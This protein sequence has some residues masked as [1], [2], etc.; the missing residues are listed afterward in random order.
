MAASGSTY[1]SKLDDAM[2]K[3]TDSWFN[4]LT[5][6]ELL[7]F[8]Q[9]RNDITVDDLRNMLKHENVTLGFGVQFTV[10]DGNAIADFGAAE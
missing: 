10:A 8:L 4:S 1:S 9:D 3:A 7:Q 2:K 5:K 6:V